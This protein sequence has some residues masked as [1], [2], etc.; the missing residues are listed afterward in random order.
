[1][2]GIEPVIN[3]DSV[4]KNKIDI[5]LNL[6]LDNELLK[7]KKIICEYL[8]EICDYTNNIYNYLDNI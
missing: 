5:I 7:I 8:S 6:T 4:Y 3:E 2:I 1:M